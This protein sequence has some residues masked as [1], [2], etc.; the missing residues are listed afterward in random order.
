MS[1]F[2]CF[3]NAI[4]R[5]TG[6]LICELT[7]GAWHSSLSLSQPSSSSLFLRRLVRFFLLPLLAYR[8]TPWRLLLGRGGQRGL[9]TTGLLLRR[10]GRHHV[11]VETGKTGANAKQVARRS[12]LDVAAAELP[13]RRRRG[14]SRGRRRSKSRRRRS[15]RIS[16]TRGSCLYDS[17]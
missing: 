6:M 1:F 9:Q 5:R 7:R 8:T 3:T 13:K 16:C 2:I 17:V 4:C 11:L 12:I 10:V 14:R 15:H